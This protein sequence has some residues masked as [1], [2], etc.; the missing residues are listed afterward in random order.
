MG[1]CGKENQEVR[2]DQGQ[3]ACA[4]AFFCDSNGQNGVL[5]TVPDLCRTFRTIL[6]FCY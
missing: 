6:A 3:S 5:G 4:T 1:N 2:K